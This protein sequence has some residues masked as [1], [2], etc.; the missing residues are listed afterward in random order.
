MFLAH[1]LS[2]T[3]HFK[4]KKK[5]STFEIMFYFSGKDPSRA[6]VGKKKGLRS[7]APKR[8]EYG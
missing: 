2:T 7:A 1:V 6:S 4:I 5:L 8:R 3:L